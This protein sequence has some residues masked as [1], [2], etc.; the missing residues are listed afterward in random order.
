[1]QM[2]KTCVEMCIRLIVVF[3]LRIFHPI[4]HRW[5]AKF[6]KRVAV[7]VGT[8]G[9]RFYDEGICSKTGLDGRFFGH[10]MC[11]IFRNVR[12]YETGVLN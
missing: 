6:L 4:K 5:R 3:P 8:S 9:V 10:K 2:H 11:R 12:N 1:M 7:A